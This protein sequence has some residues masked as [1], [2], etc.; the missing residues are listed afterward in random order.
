MDRV[1]FDFES[2][3]VIWDTDHQK[4][5]ELVPD[6]DDRKAAILA[7]AGYETVDLKREAQCLLE[8]LG[9]GGRI[10]A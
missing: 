6:L 1:T 2:G 9:L 5:T 3:E 7:A 10:K 4:G 8:E